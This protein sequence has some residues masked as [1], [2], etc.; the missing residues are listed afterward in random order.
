MS[1]AKPWESDMKVLLYLLV[2]ASAIIKAPLY[3]EDIYSIERIFQKPSLN[4]AFNNYRWIKNRDAITYIDKEINTILYLDIDDGQYKR[5]VDGNSISINGY[6]ITINDYIFD[7]NFEYVILKTD[8]GHLLYSMSLKRVKMVSHENISYPAFSPNGEYISFIKNNNLYIYEIASENYKQ[9]TYDGSIDVLNGLID[10]VYGEEIYGRSDP[11]GYKW[12]PDSRYIAYYRMIERDVKKIPLITM[13][14]LYEEVTYQH[15]PTAGTDNPVVY[16]FNYDTLLDKIK[17][18]AS[19]IEY[20]DDNG[21][22]PFYKWHPDSD[23]LLHMHIDRSQQHMMLNSYDVNT[24]KK[25][26]ILEEKDP[27]WVSI[28]HTK[29]FLYI[30]KNNMFIWCSEK[31]GFFHLYLGNLKTGELSQITRGEW[32]IESLEYVDEANKK[33]YFISTKE[34]VIERHLYIVNFDGTALEKITAKKGTHS[35]KISNNGKYFIDY[36]SNSTHPTTVYLK[37]IR[38]SPVYALDKN[39]APIKKYNLAPTEFFSITSDTGDTF[40]CSLIKPKNFNPAKKYPIIVYIYGG[41]HAQ[42]VRDRWGGNQYLLNQYMANHGYLVF[43]MDNRGTWGK[44]KQWESTL[45]KEFGK[46]ELEDQLV[47]INYLKTLP[48]ID[49]ERIGIRGWS[50]GGFMTTYAMCNA[51]DIFKVGVAGGP[52]IDWEN[53][54]TIY[55]ERYLKTPQDNPDGYFNSSVINFA[56]MMEGKYLIIHGTSDDNVHFRNSLQMIH[57]LVE[58][59]KNIDVMIYPSEKHGP[60]STSSLHLYNKT[61]NYFFDNL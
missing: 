43:S 42:L 38:N 49:S 9:I 11:N 39:E 19:S 5:L 58:K 21:Y 14:P 27:Y 53:Y 4:G 23:E 52:V 12:S 10:W 20:Y 22:I 25:R 36:Y 55:T 29:D 17:P 40:H 26:N 7:V 34:S 60:G 13:D 57:T 35:V 44:G 46:Y 45:Y 6:N 30:L 37:D 28:D 18:V 8:K 56:D 15:Y 31:D 51:S 41:P 61:A 2:I 54:D 32:Q 24:S 48:Y 47:G 59:N 33:I 3:A 16:I 1:V 50:Y